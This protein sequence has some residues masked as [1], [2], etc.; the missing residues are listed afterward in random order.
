MRGKAPKIPK[1]ED[2]RLAPTV[3]RPRQLRNDLNKNIDGINRDIVSGSYLHLIEGF[4]N[5]ER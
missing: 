5:F 4:P 2:R 3:S 1:V